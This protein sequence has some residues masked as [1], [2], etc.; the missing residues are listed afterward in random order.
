[1][2][3][4]PTDEHGRTEPPVDG[5]EAATLRGFLRYQRDTFAWK[6]SGLDAEDLARTLPPTSMT[7]GGMVKHLAYVEDDWFQRWTLGRE[8]PEP[9][10]SVDWSQDPDWEWHSAAD[11]AP[12]ALRQLWRDA[13]TRS[14][15]AVEQA[16]ADGGLGRPA[17]RAWQDGSRASLR[18]VLVHM[19]EEYA[20]HN[21][22]ADLL[23][24]SV[25]GLVGE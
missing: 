24:E 12:D 7:L 9:W 4:T 6:T 13:V 19:I 20:R 23:R 16:L 17:D 11:D 5:D 2:S 15:A 3:E 25:D 14:D 8:R 1:M 21:G 18:W 22:H 10:A